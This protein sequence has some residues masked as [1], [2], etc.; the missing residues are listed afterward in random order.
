ML[1]A[2]VV[3]VV[4]ELWWPTV[5]AVQAVAVVVGEVNQARVTLQIAHC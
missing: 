5:Q 1:V 4:L 3:L 2:V